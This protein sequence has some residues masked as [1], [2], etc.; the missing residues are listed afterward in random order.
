[1]ARDREERE[2]SRDREKRHKGESKRRHKEKQREGQDD[3][4]KR[5][6]DE[7]LTVEHSAHCLLRHQHTDAK[8]IVD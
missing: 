3:G 6:R 5:G 2:L 4:R 7:V 1:M 8:L